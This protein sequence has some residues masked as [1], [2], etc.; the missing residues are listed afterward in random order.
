MQRRDGLLTLY[1][2]H[3]RRRKAENGQTGCLRL[4]GRFYGPEASLIGRR[5]TLSLPTLSSCNHQLQDQLT[6]AE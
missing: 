1:I 4:P 2:Q 5:R 3:E 6:V